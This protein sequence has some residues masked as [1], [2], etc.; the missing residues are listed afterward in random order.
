MSMVAKLMRAVA[1]SNGTAMPICWPGLAEGAWAIS[2]VPWAALTSLAGR[3]VK[4]RRIGVASG[5]PLESAIAVGSM[6]N[7]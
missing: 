2:G 3:M 5:L 4:L 1:G 7:W 6:R